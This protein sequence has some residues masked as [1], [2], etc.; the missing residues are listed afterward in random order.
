VGGVPARLIRTRFEP[1]IV[2]RLLA[3]RWW[4]YDLT[5]FPKKDLYTDIREFLRFLELAGDLSVLRPL[6]VPRFR[7]AIGEGGLSVTRLE[8]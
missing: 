6:Q 5:Q 4:R 2:A 7:I 8:Q 1:A 3:V